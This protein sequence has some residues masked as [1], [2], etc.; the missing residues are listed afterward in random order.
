[1]ARPQA[2]PRTT[3]AGEGAA[4]PGGELVAPAPWVVGEEGWR[5]LTAEFLGA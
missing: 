2:A 1:M 3:F 5:A 4:A